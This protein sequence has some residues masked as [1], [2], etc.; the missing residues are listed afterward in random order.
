MPL[1]NQ[2]LQEIPFNLTDYFELIDWTGR[3][4]R[5]DKHGYIKQAT[6]PILE[7]LDVNNRD[8]LIDSN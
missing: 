7:R 4:I 6:P 1:D 2:K 8:W 5:E 3:I